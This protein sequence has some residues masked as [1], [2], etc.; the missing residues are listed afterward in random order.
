MDFSMETEVIDM[1]AAFAKVREAQA[2]ERAGLPTQNPFIEH[3]EMLL[4][5]GYATAQRIQSLAMHLWNDGD[6]KC[7]IGALAALADSKH[8]KIAMDM[9]LW[10]RVHGENDKDFMMLCRQI[11]EQRSAF[12]TGIA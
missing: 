8:W 10:Y 9:I 7:E 1:N 5:A 11:Y 2:A 3:R 4:S 12:K 6:Y